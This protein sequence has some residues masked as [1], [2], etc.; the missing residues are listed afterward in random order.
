[1]FFEANERTFSIGFKK[2]RLIGN[3]SVD[4]IVAVTDLVSIFTFV[5]SLKFEEVRLLELLLL[6]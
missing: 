1:M 4:Q 2:L 6:D 3:S 5:T